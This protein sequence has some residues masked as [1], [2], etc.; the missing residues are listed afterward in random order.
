MKR[1]EEI[2]GKIVAVPEKAKR[3]LVVY[4]NKYGWRCWHNFHVTPEDAAQ[5]FLVQEAR[6]PNS[7][8]QYYTV[9]EVE[10]PIP[11]NQ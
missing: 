6:N 11:I 7:E 2:K 8:N 1:L 3:Y 5:E 9:I 10:L 4:W